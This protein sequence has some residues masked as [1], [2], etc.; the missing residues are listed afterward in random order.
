MYVTNKRTLNLGE[1]RELTLGCF[2]CI[3]EFELILKKWH[4]LSNA[5]VILSDGCFLTKMMSL[6]G[7][8][9]W[10]SL[11]PK[12][13]RCTR[14]KTNAECKTKKKL[15][16]SDFLSPSSKSTEMTFYRWKEWLGLQKMI[17]PPPPPPCAQRKHLF[18]WMCFPLSVYQVFIFS[19]GLLLCHHKE[20]SP[21]IRPVP[22]TSLL[23]SSPLSLSPSILFFLL[24]FTQIHRAI[25]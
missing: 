14:H 15:F 12:F 11:P 3:F 5:L 10:F 24:V 20:L 7:G 17:S 9:V 2:F 19:S 25:Q 21:G 18:S 23:P 22:R 4:N 6:P 13:F 1:K 8:F 16:L